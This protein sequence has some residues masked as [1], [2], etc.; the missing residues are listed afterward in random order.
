MLITR[1]KAAFSTNNDP[2]R[3]LLVK[4][5]KTV[6]NDIGEGL[7]AKIFEQSKK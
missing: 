5:P 3:R 4:T 1:I 6:T 2:L 7:L